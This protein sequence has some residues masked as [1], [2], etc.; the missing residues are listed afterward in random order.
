MKVA[1]KFGVRDKFDRKYEVA[2]VVFEEEVPDWVWHLIAVCTAEDVEHAL[3][4]YADPLV[5][6]FQYTPKQALDRVPDDYKVCAQYKNC[7]MWNERA[8]T[9]LKKNVCRLLEVPTDDPE[10]SVVLTDVVN[11]WRDGFYVVTDSP[12][13]SESSR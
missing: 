11:L 5:R 7:V 6:T 8:C 9:N 3:H 12:R 2:Q 1:R 4:R 10:L 13:P